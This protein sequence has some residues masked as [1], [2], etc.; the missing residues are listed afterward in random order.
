MLKP[1][2]FA[3]I[4]FDA[5]YELLNGSGNSRVDENIVLNGTAQGLCLNFAGAALVAGQTHIWSIVWTEE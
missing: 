2:T 5:S 4:V 1:A 3:S